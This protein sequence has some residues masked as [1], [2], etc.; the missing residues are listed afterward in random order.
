MIG[1]KR[2]IICR[3]VHSPQFLIFLFF[4][5]CCYSTLQSLSQ[6]FWDCLNQWGR[7]CWFVDQSASSLSFANSCTGLKVLPGCAHL[8]LSHSIIFSFVFFLFFFA[9]FH[10]HLFSKFRVWDKQI[11][12]VFC[13]CLYF[14]QIITS[15]E[16]ECQVALTNCFQC[17]HSLSL[18]L[19]RKT[20]NEQRLIRF[21]LVRNIHRNR[22]RERERKATNNYNN[23]NR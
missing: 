6:T 2:F 23:N 13:V 1:V 21:F 4:S 19:N 18:E 10:F 12:V 16:H 9:F 15:S 17:R 5:L 22:E 11:C 7:V 3:L 20:L 8:P 14:T